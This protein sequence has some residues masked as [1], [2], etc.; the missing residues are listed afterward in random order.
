MLATISS[1]AAPE[2][3][4]DAALKLQLG[5]WADLDFKYIWVNPSRPVWVWIFMFASSGAL[6]LYTL[7]LISRQHD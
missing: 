3:S 6:T 2:G 7:H 4:G 1:Y 5:G